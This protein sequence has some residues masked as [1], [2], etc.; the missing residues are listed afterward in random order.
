MN[1]DIF[2][3]RTKEWYFRK[4]GRIVVPK[5]ML[6]TLKREYLKEL[7]DPENSEIYDVEQTGNDEFR[8]RI[9]IEGDTFLV[10]LVP[11]EALIGFYNFSFKRI[12]SDH[13]KKPELKDSPK[14]YIMDLNRYEYGLTNSGN[15]IKVLKYVQSVLYRFVKTHSPRGVVFKDY[16]E[17]RRE[18]VYNYIAKK[19]SKVSGYFLMEANWAFGQLRG[20]ITY[21]AKIHGIPVLFVN[22]AYTSQACSQCNHSEEENRLTQELFRCKRCGYSANADYN[23]SVNISRAAVIRPIVGTSKMVTYKPLPSGRGQ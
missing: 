10:E 15:P 18:K 2:E 11:S 13:I 6:P 19:L 5:K 1:T 17:G 22:P 4:S 21:K 9:Q 14:K 7:L 3:S 16:D 23:A 20:F 8:K 12:H